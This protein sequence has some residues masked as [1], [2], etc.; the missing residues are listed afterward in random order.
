MLPWRRPCKAVNPAQA[1]APACSNV[2]LA[3]LITNPR[4]RAHAYSAR[5]G[6]PTP[7]TSSPGLNCVTFLPTLSTVPATSLPSPVFSGVRSPDLRRSG[8]P[9][10][11]ARINKIEG[12]RVNSDQDL[13]VIRSRLFNVYQGE[14]LGS[15]LLAVNDR[16]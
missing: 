1:T 11:H 8:Q 6:R 4:S 9:S 12:S 13:I 10:H 14:N 7:K 15:P 3:G 5:E 16:F 2:T